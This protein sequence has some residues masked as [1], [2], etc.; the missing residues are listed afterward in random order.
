M[1]A[2]IAGGD[3]TVGETPD[4]WREENA[5]RA[6]AYA[7]AERHADAVARHQRGLARALRKLREIEEKKGQQ[8]TE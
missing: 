7:E 6:K 4:D 1:S 8:T 5:A 2:A 3:R